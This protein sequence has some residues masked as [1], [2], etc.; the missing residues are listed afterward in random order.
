MSKRL[1]LVLAL[2]FVVG[3]ACAAY[4]ETQN[5]KVSGDIEMLG[6]RRD[7][8]LHDDDSKYVTNILATITR[9]R[10]DA[11]LTD[12]VSATVRLIN[13]RLWG[14]ESENTMDSNDG[15]GNPNTDIQLD[16]AY[17][18][19]K[20]FLYS[21]LTLTVGR[22]ELH[23]GND[24]I[25]GAFRTNNNADDEATP[26]GNWGLDDLSKHKA[27]DAIR[28]TLN[29]DPLILDI[30]TAKIREYDIDEGDDIDL[31]GINA[32][33]ALGNRGSFENTI[34]EGY[35]WEKHERLADGYSNTDRVDVLG[36]RIATNLKGIQL[37]LELAWQLGK[38][39]ASSQTR[40]RNAF[41]VETSAGYDFTKSKWSPSVMLGYS[42]FSG[43]RSDDTSVVTSWD[44]MFENQTAGHIWNALFRQTNVHVLSLSG[45]VKPRTDITIKGDYNVY[46]W[47]K[48][49]RPEAKPGSYDFGTMNEW[50]SN[51]Y[52]MNHKKFAGQ[53]IDLTG[54]YDYTE[55]VQFKLLAGIL[56]PGGSFED[57]ND[58]V[59][60][61]VIG[62]MKVTF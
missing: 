56:V 14:K 32:N 4:A 1:I 43:N 10:I 51:N 29:Y 41:A 45:S 25:I 23:F 15:S 37:Q 20:E 59:A 12:N 27:F 42:Y 46:F 6:A 61:E 31:Y 35:W 24:M 60:S 34:L 18:T 19:L 47:D 40:H 38:M 26:F 16:L 49:L 13:E 5:V 57:Q 33:Y 8:F 30:V 17:V 52:S 54:T 50:W 48:R 3:I 44:P 53:E 22:Q 55:D 11:D 9:L 21:P 7:L 36:G 28:A 39:A 58:R 2:A 62:S